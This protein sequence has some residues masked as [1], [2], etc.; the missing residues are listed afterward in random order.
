MKALK[1]TAFIAMVLFVVGLL[2]F[3][4]TKTVVPIPRDDTHLGM[5][6]ETKCLDCHGEGKEY[7]RKDTHPPKDMCFNCHKMKK[8]DTEKRD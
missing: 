4:S 5:K 8:A 1:H 6:E 7:A 3:F 2:Y